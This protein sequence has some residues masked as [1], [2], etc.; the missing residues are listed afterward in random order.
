ML[1]GKLT[2]GHSDCERVL[3][4]LRVEWRWHHHITVYPLPFAV[5]PFAVCSWR[6]L[7]T[8]RLLLWGKPPGST[9]SRTPHHRLAPCTTSTQSPQPSSNGLRAARLGL[10]QGVGPIG[11]RAGEMRRTMSWEIGTMSE[12]VV[13]LCLPHSAFRLCARVCSA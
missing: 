13:M 3:A 4:L 12:C 10:G 5:L 6:M 7:R 9:H 1:I 2:C 8:R 11:C